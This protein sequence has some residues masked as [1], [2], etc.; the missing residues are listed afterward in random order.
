MIHFPRKLLSVVR[1]TDRLPA[2]R[3]PRCRAASQRERLRTDLVG[4]PVE[5]PHAQLA[6]GR[7]VPEKMSTFPSPLLSA[8]STS[9]QADPQPEQV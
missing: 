3:A 6:G 2:R 9:R 1:E 7:V 5:Q 8:A 4:V